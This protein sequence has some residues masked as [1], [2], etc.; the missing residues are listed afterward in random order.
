MSSKDP[1]SVFSV[2]VS[3]LSWRVFKRMSAYSSLVILRWL[4]PVKGDEESYEAVSFEVQCRFYPE[5]YISLKAFCR[6]HFKMIQPRELPLSAQISNMRQIA[7]IVDLA[8]WNI[9]TE[10]DVLVYIEEIYM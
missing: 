8:K 2:F 7:E 10:L 4:V 3:L 9:T 6:G 5:E 1:V